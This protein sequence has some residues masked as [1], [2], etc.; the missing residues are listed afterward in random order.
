MADMFHLGWFTN[1]LTPDWKGPWAGD[2]GRRWTN[3]DFYLDMART[4]DRV[5]F[6]FIMLEDS[7][8]LSDAYA[9]SFEM[10]MRHMVRAPKHDPVPLVPLLGHVTNGLGLIATASTSLYPPYLLAR[11]MTTLDHLTNGRAGWN[12]VTTA[13]SGAE[14]NYGF[15][16]G[17]S[18]DELYGRA[19]E[20]ATVVES[21]WD[22]WEPGALVNDPESGV[23]VDHTKISHVDHVGDHFS[24]RGPLNT[25]PSPQGRPVML[26]AGGSP[27]GRR[28]AARHADAVV[29]LPK[30]LEE[31][32]AY[33]EDITALA[34]EAGRD[35]GCVK[36]FYIVSPVIGETQADAE[37]MQR[38]RMADTQSRVEKRLLL[39][40]SGG[41][42]FSKVPLDVPLDPDDPSMLPGGASQ[43]ITHTFLRTHAGKTLRQAASIDQTEAI[44]LVGT[45]DRVA[46]LMEEAMTEAG[47]DGF[48][49]YSGSGQLTRRYL[50]EITDGLVPVLQRRGLVR[51]DYSHPQLRD[52][53]LAF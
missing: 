9:G 27:V 36:V 3:G 38:R 25:L 20:F 21:L 12:I 51:T 35:P 45:A 47:G 1:Y 19:E 49:V 43:S 39:M 24:V 28:F 14:Q 23:Y 50:A 5:G 22:S 40:S 37:E 26:Q 8:F 16:T 4:L 30:G 32:R 18:H 53:L 11:T 46:A 34:K 10:E 7:S 2:A 42:D 52:N 13:G 31:M 33:R 15:P 48:L 29:A 6:D 41:A 17:T 44:E